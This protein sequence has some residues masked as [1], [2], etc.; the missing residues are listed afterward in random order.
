MQRPAISWKMWWSVCPINLNW[1]VKVPF[2]QYLVQTFRHELSRITF[3]YSTNSNVLSSRFRLHVAGLFPYLFK[4]GLQACTPF[5]QQ[6]DV[7]F[8]N[9]CCLFSH[10]HFGENVSKGHVQLWYCTSHFLSVLLLFSAIY[11]QAR[12]NHREVL[13]QNSKYFEVLVI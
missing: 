7:G 6:L 2:A 5:L 1:T 4:L 11:C 3:L 8:V 13:V 12:T 9:F 10:C